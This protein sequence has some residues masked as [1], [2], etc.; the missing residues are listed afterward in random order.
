[1]LT[2]THDVPSCSWIETP[3]RTSARSRAAGP[4]QCAKSRSTQL[5]LMRRDPGGRGQG[6]WSVVSSAGCMA[7]V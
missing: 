1:M 3:G 4:G 6:R 7:R 2:S 5:C